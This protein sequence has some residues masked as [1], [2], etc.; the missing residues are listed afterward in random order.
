MLGDAQPR[1]RN[2]DDLPS[3]NRVGFDLSQICL[4][5]GADRD[6]MDDQF[7]WAYREFQVMSC[8]ASLATRFLS[9]ALALASRLLL[10]GKP[11]RGGRQVAVVAVRGQPL[12]ESLHL[13]TQALDRFFQQGNTLHLLLQF[14]VLS[15]KTDQ[16]FFFCHACTLS[17]S[18][19]FDK[20]SGL[21]R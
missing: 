14:G 15:S 21:L 10:P 3:F 9:A 18:A 11:I 12:M 19:C 7:I 16:F 6:G 5:V 20:S 4:T 8:V 17:A 2:I 13:F 1:W